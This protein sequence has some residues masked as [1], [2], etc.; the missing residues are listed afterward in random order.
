MKVD[1]KTSR[2]IGKKASE[3]LRLLRDTDKKYFDKDEFGPALYSRDYNVLYKLGE[4][5]PWFE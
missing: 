1:K 2:E 3:L 5:I 4:I